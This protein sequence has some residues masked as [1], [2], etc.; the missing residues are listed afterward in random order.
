VQLNESASQAAAPTV[1]LLYD[2]TKLVT[3]RLGTNR[4]RV[5][6]TA[7]V[8][9]INRDI[10]ADRIRPL[11]DWVNQCFPGVSTRQVIPWAGLRPMIPNM[12]PRVGPGA[13]SNVFYKTGHG[14]LGWTLSAITAF[15]LTQHVAR[16]REAR[17]P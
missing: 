10:R 6:G 3:N 15:Q 1:S 2:A 5:A 14:Q 11:V 16:W 8:N 13:K 12:M 9:G 7:E 17:Q 4:F